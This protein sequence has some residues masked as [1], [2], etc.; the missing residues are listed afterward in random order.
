MDFSILT[1]KNKLLNEV[2]SDSSRFL[3][4]ISEILNSSAIIFRHHLFE[5]LFSIWFLIFSVKVTAV[6]AIK[7]II[8]S[9]LSPF[10]KSSMIISA[11][12]VHYLWRS[13]FY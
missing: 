6:D 2:P 4:E 7:E 12:S 13:R 8:I 9:G 5:G 1:F 10:E 11:F 3:T